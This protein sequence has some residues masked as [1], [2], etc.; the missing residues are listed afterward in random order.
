MRLFERTLTR[1]EIAPHAEEQDALGGVRLSFSARR[2]PVRGSLQPDANALGY[3]SGNLR[4][5]AQGLRTV[6]RLRALLPRD[7][8]IA[9]GD[10]VC[11]D[12]A[13]QPQW[14]VLSV[15]NWTAHKLVRLER[16]L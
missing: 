16:R 15:E 12:G 2:V 11:T 4:Q 14:L 3:S 5:E 13:P 8:E 9:P 1:M 7:A 10:G 6:Q